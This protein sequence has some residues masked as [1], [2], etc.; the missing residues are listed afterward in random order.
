MAEAVCRALVAER[1]G[2]G[3]D[4]EQGETGTPAGPRVVADSAG[5][6]GWHVGEPAD[7]RATE[8]LRAAGYD[9]ADDWHTA[10]RFEAAWFDRYDLVVALDRGHERTLRRLAPTPEA[11]AKIRLL[12][13]DGKDVLDPY[14][15]DAEDFAQCLKVIQDAM[16][17]LLASLPR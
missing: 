4:G 1:A 17:G 11:A 5:T 14:Y 12:R 8:A 6:G 2:E 16:P 3:P 10:R 7:P 13:G 9:L 15:G